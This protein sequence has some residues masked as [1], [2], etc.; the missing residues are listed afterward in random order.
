MK[1]IY[2][3]LFLFL[4]TISL[5]ATPTLPSNG[6]WFGAI[7]GGYFN[8]GWIAGNGARRAIVCKAGSMPAFVPQNGIQYTANTAFGQGQEVAPGE[9]IIYDHFS[10]S[11]FLTALNP[12]TTYYFKIFDYNGTG[13]STEYLT[14]TFLSGNATTSAT[15]T[16][17]TSSATFTNITTNS[18]TVNWTNGN[19]FRRLVVVREGSPVT[20]DP[21]SGTA[22]NVSSA[23]GNG[24]TIGAGN[25]TVYASTGT[26]TNVTNLKSNTQYFFSFYEYNGNSQPQY[27]T[28][29]YTTSV[30]TRSIPTIASSGLTI[31]KTDGKELYLNWANGNGQRRIIVAKQGSDITSLPVNGT[32]YNANAVFGSGQQLVNGTN[33]FVVYDDNFN[34][35][36]ISG[37]N[38]ATTYYFKIF[39]YDGTGSNATYLTS[40]FASV[41]GST[42]ITPT[43]QSQTNAASNISSNS[44]RLSLVPGNGRARLIIAR[45]NEAV[46][47]SPVNF[48]SYVANSDF[49][50]GH[51]FGNGNYVV[52]VSTE[53]SATIH[54]LEPNTT[55]HFA[56]FE[57]NGFNQPLYL[58][59]A[60]ITNATTSATLP[61][62]LTGWEAT[63]AN[64]KVVLHWKT[65]AEINTSHFIVERSSDATNFSS[66]L[67]ITARGNSQNEV[68]YSGEDNN[69]LQDKSFYRLKMVD[70]DGKF[71]YAAVRVVIFSSNPVVKMIRNPVQT[72]LQVISSGNKTGEWEIIN[73]VGQIVKR[74]VLLQGRTEVNVSALP[75]GNYWLRTSL[76]QKAETIAFIKQ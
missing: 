14:S 39:E 62:K 45:K 16:T 35:A 65:S 49:G 52:A 17:Q 24:A 11:F 36:T 63:A 55:Y 34:A 1:F 30:I 3:L 71:E 8:F 9:F 68:S 53:S 10:T 44:L 76:A 72:T 33:E 74:G 75:A 32:D 47:V 64:N 60:A 40:S 51:H 23:L 27:E 6:L 73:K 28:P 67:T 56:I 38:P 31:A 25:F 42:V 19:G 54:A 29:A 61:V 43:Q 69:P 22:Y 21:V 59:P 66:I 5:A 4:S 12:A 37:L 70:N 58:T 50:T 15:P 48:T 13:A 18:V 2:T 57:L 26:S 41:N 20:A 46:N 7:D